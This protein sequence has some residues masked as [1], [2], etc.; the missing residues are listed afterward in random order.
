MKISWYPEGDLQFSV[1]R[2]KGQQLKY[3]RNKSTH[4]T[5]T[6]CAIS[7]GVMN[8]I[9]ILTSQKPSLNSE[10][11]DKVYPDHTNYLHEAGLAPP[12]FPKTGY[13]WKIQDEKLDIENEK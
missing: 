1:F 8:R 10:G 2:N 6:L 3:V 9:S 5:G 4:T 13:L 11:L 12:N 7:S